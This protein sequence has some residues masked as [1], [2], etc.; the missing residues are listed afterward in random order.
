MKPIEPPAN[1]QATIY[2]LFDPAT[3]AIQGWMADAQQDTCGEN[4]LPSPTGAPVD[5]ARFYVRA[6]R[7]LPRPDNPARLDGM[8]LRDVPRF[9]TI[10]I[11]GQRYACDDGSAELQ[12]AYPGRYQVSIE[13]FPAQHATFEVVK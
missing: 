10:V 7:L 8:V 6:G 5:G 9:A 3:G 1:A 13:C 2:V 11:N 4:C 12:F